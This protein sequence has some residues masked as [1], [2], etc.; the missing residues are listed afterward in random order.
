MKIERTMIVKLRGLPSPTMAVIHMTEMQTPQGSLDHAY[1][2][3]F[4]SNMDYRTTT[5]ACDLLQVIDPMT[6]GLSEAERV[7]RAI[8]DP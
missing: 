6:D 2:C 8:K 3:W 5:L 7:Y 4:D 1:V